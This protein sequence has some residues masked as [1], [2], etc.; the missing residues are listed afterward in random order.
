MRR[1]LIHKHPHVLTATEIQMKGSTGVVDSVLRFGS[2]DDLMGHFTSL[3]APNNALEAA[4]R[5]VETTRIAS[6]E[7]SSLPS[8]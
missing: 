1:F 5:S 3:G 4:R 8:A 6:L 2:V 7:F